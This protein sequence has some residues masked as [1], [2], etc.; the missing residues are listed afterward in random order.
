MNKPFEIV[1]DE[2][3]A[4][5]GSS[6]RLDEAARAAWLHF[7]AGHTQQR[8]AD[9]LGISRQSAQR[10]ISLAV[11]AKLVRI[12]VVHP[13]ARCMALAE[14]LRRLLKLRS[15]TVVPSDPSSMSGTLGVAEEVAAQIERL[16][17]LEAPLILGIGTGRTLSAAAS[18]VPPMNCPQHRIVACVGS[19]S[20]EGWATFHD[21]VTKLANTVR[22]PHYP[23][24]VPVMA[25]SAEERQVLLD[26][27][28]V[29]KVIELARRADVTFLGI[30]HL[31][32]GATLFEDGF[33]TANELKALRKAGAV[34]EM[35]GWSFDADGNFITGLTNDRVVSIPPERDANAR[36]AGVAKGDR[37]VPAIL[38]AIRGR[39]INE[40]VTDERTAEQL[41][42]A[43]R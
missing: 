32:E 30:G 28:P 33:V 22:A 20:I 6:D 34:G 4:N 8:V 41:L 5:E 21:V 7:V 25:N 27:K 31:Q 29:R 16:L 37:K 9:A 26:Q 40:L 11:E 35:V 19:T 10:L 2:A 1:G 12:E 24:P 43:R 13:I 39:L 36:V 3:P 38:G 17:R 23:M 14:E 15:C 18:K 42:A